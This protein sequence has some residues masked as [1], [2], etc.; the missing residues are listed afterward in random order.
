MTNSPP[1]A[2]HSARLTLRALDARDAP[3]LLALYADAGVMRFWNHA[4]WTSM[5][6]ADAAIAEAHADY[7]SG[8]SQHYAIARTADGALLGSCA[9]YACAPAHRRASLG[10]LLSAPYWGQ[11]Y[12]SEAIHTLI[13]DAFRT[14]G[15]NR[16]E[17][18]VNAA[19]TASAKALR[20]LGFVLEASRRER[21]IVAGA[22]V[23]TQS[24]ALLRDDWL[25]AR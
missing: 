19:N 16:I 9:L 2:L 20:K 22:K 23:D 18:D 17:A 4:A 12:A 10:Y 8:A 24:F 13:D 15:L 6:D 5:A 3:A 25:A 14:R 11:G 21:W 7:A 1:A